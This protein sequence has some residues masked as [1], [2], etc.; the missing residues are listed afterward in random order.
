VSGLS[1]TVTTMV[2]LLW[3]GAVLCEPCVAVFPAGDIQG[4]WRSF[5]QKVKVVR[6]AKSG[7]RS[8][9]I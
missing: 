2:S 3:L 7:E 6:R 1:G 8:G 9:S 4:E 5:D